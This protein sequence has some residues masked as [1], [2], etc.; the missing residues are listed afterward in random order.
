MVGDIGLEFTPILG[1][2]DPQLVTPQ[3]CVASQLKWQKKWE[4]DSHFK[5]DVFA[6]M[7]GDIGLEPMTPCL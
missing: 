7:V 3:C 5:Y 4:L 6:Q 2:Y 1:A